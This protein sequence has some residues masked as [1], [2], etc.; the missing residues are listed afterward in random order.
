[1]N[2]I[3]QRLAR[4]HLLEK[5]SGYR[6]KPG[7]VAIIL[8]PRLDSLPVIVTWLSASKRQK[9]VNQCDTQ[10]ANVNDF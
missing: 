1:M 2:T 8:V 5:F 6:L 4:L 3:R 7:N 9:S 10:S